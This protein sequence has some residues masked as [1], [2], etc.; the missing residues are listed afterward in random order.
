MAGEETKARFKIYRRTEVK[1]KHVAEAKAQK[2]FAV[3]NSSGNSCPVPGQPH[4]QEPYDCSL[5][6][7]KSW[8]NARIRD[9]AKKGHFC[10]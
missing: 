3:S 8:R 10:L 6:F 2:A 5:R 7:S 1:K 4:G 9:L